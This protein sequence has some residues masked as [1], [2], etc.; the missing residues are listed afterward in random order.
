HEE[1]NLLL[2]Y[3]DEKGLSIEEEKSFLNQKEE[4]AAEVQLC[5]IVGDVIVG[6]AGVSAI[7]AREK[8][9]HRA[10]LGVSIEK[11]YWS[12]GIGSAL[13]AACIECA[14]KAGFRQLELEVVADNK[15]AI[16]LYPKM[17]FIEYGRNPRG[18]VSRS[19]GYQELI[20][21]RLELC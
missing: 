3:P 2:T 7:G 1:T 20:M 9:S 14:A 5:A 16:A 17:G 15:N 6:L 11:D 4:S 21:M 19:S 8:I 12:L 13:T 18:F 10:K